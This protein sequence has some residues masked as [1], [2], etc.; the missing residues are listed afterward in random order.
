MT[1]MCLDVL[2][3]PSPAIKPLPDSI[4]AKHGPGFRVRSDARR[5]DVRRVRGRGDPVRSVRGRAAQRNAPSPQTCP[6]CQVRRT[7]PPTQPAATST[8]RWR[9]TRTPRRR[10]RDI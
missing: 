7:S 8:P 1:Q 6:P 5:G 2:S 3:E 10:E 4:Y 9:A